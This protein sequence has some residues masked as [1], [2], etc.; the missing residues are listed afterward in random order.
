MKESAGIDTLPL[1]GLTL[2]QRYYISYP[3]ALQNEPLDELI[4]LFGEPPRKSHIP[5]WTHA[6]LLGS[7]PGDIDQVWLVLKVDPNGRIIDADTLI[8]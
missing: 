4:T 1:H 7:F 8:E 3:H 6:Y 2:A 5:E